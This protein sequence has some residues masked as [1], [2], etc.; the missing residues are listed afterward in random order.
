M[1]KCVKKS[2]VMMLVQTQGVTFSGGAVLL[3]TKGL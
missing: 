3:R 1:K 2:A